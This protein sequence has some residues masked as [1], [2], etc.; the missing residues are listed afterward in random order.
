MKRL[1]GFTLIELLVVVAIIALLIAIL[2]PSLNRARETSR[3]TVCGTQLKGQGTSFA[4]YASQFNDA[5][6]SGPDFRLS[7]S[8]FFHDNSVRFSD[9]L[10]SVNTNNGMNEDSV[11]KWFYCPSNPIYNADAFWTPTTNTNSPLDDRRLGYAYL[12]LRLGAANSPVIGGI[13]PSPSARPNPP[14]EWHTKWSTTPFPSQAEL[15]T[16]IILSTQSPS[17]LPV[18]IQFKNDPLF[19]G[20]G[21]YLV[22]YNNV[23]H[24]LGT[25]PAGGNF[26]A[27]DGHVAWKPWNPNGVVW[28]QTN[29]YSGNG[30]WFFLN[31]Q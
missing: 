29:G 4:I 19:R 22:V 8:S 15:V 7:N 26:L 13:K 6:P 11:R 18:D 12:N 5:I 20:K 3:R 23:S 14:L 27:F 24:L 17:G 16:D 25:A 21:G 28:V 10:L 31:P 9:T 2:L 1:R 30:V